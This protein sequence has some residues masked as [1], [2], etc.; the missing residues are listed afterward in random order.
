MTLLP[1]QGWTGTA[2]D[3]D[4]GKTQAPVPQYT[5]PSASCMPLGPPPCLYL[6]NHR[7]SPETCAGET[8]SKTGTRAFLGQTYSMRGVRA[9]NHVR[10]RE[11][12]STVSFIVVLLVHWVVMLPVSI[13]L[14]KGLLSPSQSAFP[15]ASSALIRENSSPQ[16]VFHLSLE[17]IMAATTPLQLFICILLNCRFQVSAAKNSVRKLSHTAMSF[18]NVDWIP[19]GCSWNNILQQL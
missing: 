14:I 4:W 7:R 18:L 15:G 2:R 1:S 6:H 3:Q 12:G 11:K 19:A 5:F 9:E 16:T 8:V 17:P 13:M 10:E